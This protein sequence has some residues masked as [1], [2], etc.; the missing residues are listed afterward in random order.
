MRAR[1]YVDG[2]NLYHAISDMGEP[3]LKWLDLWALA[4][5]V[6]PQTEILSGVT[7]CSA[8]YP[9]F[10]KKVR[11]ERYVNALI[12]RGVEPKLGHYARNDMECDG[13]GHK[14]EKPAEKESDI[15]LALAI[16]CDATDDLF[17]HG[18]LLTADTDQVATIKRIR[19]RYPTKKVSTIF[20]PGRP[21][22]KHLRD[23]S[24]TVIS[25]TKKDVE[26]SL[27]PLLVERAGCK[28]VI[29]PEEYAPTT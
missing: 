7:Y 15:N 13:C 9:N 1:V 17:D 24:H 22:S 4:A 12:L 5:K 10:Q 23:Q 2:F 25:I 21:G 18:Y 8:Y 28:S 27:L 11:H 6:I 20:P 29:R 14:W 16:Y 19:E 3:H 26:A